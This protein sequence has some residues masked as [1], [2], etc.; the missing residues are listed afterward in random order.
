[1]KI[2]KNKYLIL[3]RFI[4][5]GLLVLFL[6]PSADFILKGNLSSSLLFNSI[7]LSD[8]FAYLQIFL[9]TFTLNV[10][11]FISAFLVFIIY[12]LFLGRAFCSFV[13]PVNLITNL[14]DFIKQNTSFKSS[15]LTN[16]K[17]NTRYFILFS[18]LILCLIA[19]EPIFEKYSH[20]GII[21]RGIIF[22]QTSAIFVAIIIFLL[23]LF[24]QRNLVCSHLC[25]LGAFYSLISKFAMLKVSYDLNKCTKCMKC[26]MICPEAQ[27]LSLITK[28]SGNVS[29][30]ECIKCARCIEVCDD[31][32]LNFNLINFL[33]GKK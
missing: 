14:A 25:P 18:I 19:N 24:V 27:V 4:Q 11:L 30:S 2:L 15:K 6:L 10:G 3:R 9:A 7:S 33:K 32:A 17:Q 23:D 26:K 29:N 13:C 8:P 1:M 22:M 21:T 12:A 28:Y 20:I 5:L 31:D 16:F